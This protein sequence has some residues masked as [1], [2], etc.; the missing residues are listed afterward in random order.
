MK[1]AEVRHSDV[2]KLHRTIAKTA[3]Y[4]ANRTVS[5]LS[6]MM[7][8]AVK[9]EMRPDNPARGVERAPEEKR[10]RFLTP[11]EI[12]R[13]AEVLATHKERAS[14]NAIRLMLLTGAR[15]GE[16]LSAR[17]REF[18]LDAGVWVKPSASTKQKKEHRVP[19]SAPA[20][21]LLLEMR[22]EVDKDVRRGGEEPEFVFP[23]GGG[24]PLQDIKRVWLSVCRT[25]GLAKQ[26][27]KV[28]PNGKVVKDT[29]GE[30]VLAWQAT[31][32]VHDLRHTYCLYPRQLGSI[33]PGHR[34]SAGAHPG[35][36]LTALCPSA[37]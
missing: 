16:T 14:C 17:W 25:A 26:V 9:W 21:A 13:L 5:V 12:G 7:A 34:C 6:K 18:D 24:Q 31:A 20:V 29:K 28:G 4:R 1:V 15:R 36:D 23:G 32:R 8:L 19:L 11:A 2:E 30:P 3:P 27:E 37:G 35:G 22:A 33:A 10:E